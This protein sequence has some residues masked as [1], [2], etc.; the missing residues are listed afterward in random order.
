MRRAKKSSYL[1][2]VLG[3]VLSAPAALAGW[4][5]AASAFDAS[6]LG[7]LSESRAK[8]ISEAEQGAPRED[9]AAIHSVLDAQPTQISVGA[10]T[11]IWRCR[12]IKLGGMTPDVIY[13]WFKCRIGGRDGRL[14]FEKLTGSQRSYGTLYP[15]TSGG[16]V[17]L[18]ASSVANEPRHFYSG[19][20]ASV[21]APGTPDDQI[22]LLLA[23]GA[24]S[25]RIEFPYPVQESTFDVIEL[26]R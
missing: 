9:L 19:S 8:G 20:G 25:A 5:D 14:T 26:K 13:S 6:R 2:L 24:K 12:T 21:G 10:L 3:L 22:G 7:K 15:D 17:Y 23:T 4:Q 18:G 11:G 1:L 16:Y